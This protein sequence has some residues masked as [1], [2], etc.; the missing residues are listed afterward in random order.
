MTQGY[1]VASELLDVL[2]NE[3]EACREMVSLTLRER[4]TLQA[5][6]VSALT[7]VLRDKETVL[8]ALN[9]W[10]NARERIRMGLV[11]DKSAP[12]DSTLSQLAVHFDGESR[13][14]LEPKQKE[15]TE[16][17][18]QVMALNQGNRMLIEAD[19]ARVQATFDFIARTAEPDDGTY[20]TVNG[21]RSKPLTGN[22]FN[23]EA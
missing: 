14:A 4:S 19:L 21:S 20:T 8:E 3:V 1:D 6:D 2:S 15:L 5:G 10:H 22:V 17:V 13:R 11:R 9:A 7:A 23:W 18:R 16:L 12:T